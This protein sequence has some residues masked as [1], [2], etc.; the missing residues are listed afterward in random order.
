MMSTKSSPGPVTRRTLVGTAAGVAA[1]AALPRVAWPQG[2][3]ASGARRVD[4]VV[5]GA[6]LSGLAAARRLVRRGA[7]VVVLEARNR[8]GGRTLTVQQNGTF[9]DVGG[10]FVGNTQKRMLALAR[11]T[12]VKRFKPFTSGENLFDYHGK[13]SR[14]SDAP[15]LPGHDLVEYLSAQQ[16]LKRMAAEVPPDAPW[17]APDAE[18]R[19]WQTY[20][21][22]IDSNVETEGAR[23]LLELEFFDSS[24]GA[25]ETSLLS[26][27]W[28]I[29]RSPPDEEPDSHRLV[30]GAQQIS[31]RLARKLGSRRVV[32]GAAVR[33]L[34]HSGGMVVAESRAGSFKAKRAIVAIPPT[35]ALRIAYHPVLP[36]LRDGW[37]QHVAQGSVLKCQAIYPTPFWRAQGLSG[38]TVSDRWPFYATYDNGPPSPDGRPG[39]L[40][41]FATPNATRE[42]GQHS[43]RAR[44]RL[45]LDAFARLFGARARSPIGYV[46]GN[47]SG[48]PWTRGCYQG[49]PSSGAILGFG[50]AWREPVGAIHWA[51]GESSTAWP[52]YMEGAVRAGETAA[53]EVLAEFGAH[54]S[55]RRVTG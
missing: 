35:L 5:V 25:G 30:G 9:I 3:A 43:E 42:L 41:G 54:V 8:V 10:Q 23:T 52:G 21:S 50:K 55:S 47:W 26:A 36:A 6:G 44:R 4:V 39:V 24:I 34:K 45:A 28:A 2:A 27:L 1:G 20:Q 14:W 22:W 7:S 29:R 37:T 53:D 11:A 51:A 48:M 46:E 18:E 19:D 15:P 16:A 49:M 33:T 13:I 32:L 17:E 31:E 12:G 40:L 38:H